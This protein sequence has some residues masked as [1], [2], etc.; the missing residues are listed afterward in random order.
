MK[1]VDINNT[2]I[3]GYLQLLNNL[4]TNNK[5]DLISKLSLSVN[6]AVQIKRNIFTKVS[7][8]VT[9]YFLLMKLLMTSGK[10]GQLT[11]KPS[12]F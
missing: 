1:P 12:S 2:L 5:L 3:E 9:P 4:S 6:A 8:P 11:I 7:V 10:A